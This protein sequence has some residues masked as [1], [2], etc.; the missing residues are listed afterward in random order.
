MTHPLIVRRRAE[1]ATRIEVARTWA[2]QLG[3]RLPV[4]AVVV[5]GS[6]ARGDFNKW[7]DLDVLVVVDGLPAEA[8]GRIEL[9]MLDSPPGLQPL[10]WTPPEL[11]TRLARKDPIAVEAYES[12]VVVVGAL[13]SF[14][15]PVEP[16]PTA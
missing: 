3:R 2:A 10:G 4:K 7:S 16:G 8:L 14:P 6:V 5:V 9:L 11:A 12:G 1:R 15:R 13:P